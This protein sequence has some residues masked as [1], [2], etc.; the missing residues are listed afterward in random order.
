M[1]V[2]SLNQLLWVL[3]W[4]WLEIDRLALW[5]ALSQNRARSGPPIERAEVTAKDMNFK[6]ITTMTKIDEL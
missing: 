1:T 3:R 2:V 4:S 6:R 5:L